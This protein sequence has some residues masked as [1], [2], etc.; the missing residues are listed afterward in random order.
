MT[1]EVYE[2]PDNYILT[3][4][5]SSLW[6]SRLT[7][8]LEARPVSE[9]EKAW[10]PQSIGCMRGL[11]GK[12]RFSP[13]SYWKLLLVSHCSRIARH[14][15]CDGEI[16]KIS[17][18]IA[19]TLAPASQRDIQV[20]KE[21]GNDQRLNKEWER[22]EKRM[23]EE[24]HRMFNGSDSFFFSFTADLTNSLQ[25]QS[26]V[27][28]DKAKPLWQRADE[29]FFWN[30]HMLEGLI[31]MAGKQEDPQSLIDQW[32]I[33][34]IQG[35]VQSDVCSPLNPQHTTTPGSTVN[36][37]PKSSPEVRRRSLPGSESRDL[38]D[39]LIVS[40]RSRHNAGT[41]FKRRGV[42]E[43]G[44]V[45]NYVETEWIVSRPPNVASFLQI[46][47]S[48][49]VFWS[50]PSVWSQPSGKPRLTG[51]E[52]EDRPVFAKHF[53]EELAVFDRI[54]AVN[55]VNKT[56]REAVIGSMYEKQA[57]LYNNENLL[58][59]SFDFH[60]YC[61]GMRYDRIQIL[62]ENLQNVI[63]QMGFCWVNNK[64]KLCKQ[65][66]VFRV[67]CMDCLDRT[68]LVQ[69]A[70]ARASFRTILWKFG[71]LH[72]E[73]PLPHTCQLLYQDMWANNGDVISR[74]YAGTDAL[75]GDF[76][77][78]GERRFTGI[79][80]DGVKSANRYYVNRFRDTYRQRVINT[81]Q[82]I[83]VGNDFVDIEPEVDVE[84]EDD[85]Q[86]L[87]QRRGNL[88]LLIE[89]CKK[90]LLDKSE[91]SASKGW[92][93]VIPSAFRTHKRGEEKDEEVILLLTGSSFY[94][95]RYD[96]SCDDITEYE[97]LPLEE[98]K[99]IV[100]GGEQSKSGRQCVQFDCGDNI[101]KTFTTLQSRNQSKE[102]LLMT[103]QDIADTFTS[104]QE[105]QG[106][107]KVSV[108]RRVIQVKSNAEKQSLLGRVMQ[109]TQNPWKRNKGREKKSTDGPREE[110]RQIEDGSIRESSEERDDE[111]SGSIRESSEERDDEA[112]G[113]GGVSES[114]GLDGSLCVRMLE[115]GIGQRHDQP[116]DERARGS[117]S[118]SD[119]EKSGDEMAEW[120][121][122]T[123]DIDNQFTA[124]DL[125]V[126][127]QLDDLDTTEGLEKEKDSEVGFDSPVVAENDVEVVNEEAR[128]EDDTEVDALDDFREDSPP[129]VEE[130][131]DTD[132]VV[133]VADASQFDVTPEVVKAARRM[134]RTQFFDY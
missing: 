95:V 51:T 101:V 108:N 53:D 29:R 63:S 79:V 10:S 18:I 3:N 16:Y 118:V 26:S 22:I 15:Q 41:R 82:G 127:R 131:D 73:E 74:Q 7:G 32:I 62:A 21:K 31:V 134:S 28:Y 110:S 39:L 125:H 35:F 103:L 85:K 64:G 71:L 12:I 59:V 60:K 77:R 93:L 50:Q 81:M 129:G 100:I 111:A 24:L 119:V 46:R 65:N 72:P 27:G 58:F 68:N 42:D 56:G 48:I 90:R 83:D 13:K 113:S 37:S 99:E 123:K 94:I 30:R 55:L 76:T 128:E 5:E 75:K 105:S 120:R 44:H 34:V 49:P 86:W 4:G 70:L 11:I 91:I 117:E 97:H 84:L 121:S 61:K 80:K 47:G 36:A 130:E 14:P 52:A 54:V 102:E 116:N 40:R 8:H 122:T 38:C 112:S 6:C 45:A 23:D 98:V 69:C 66:S 17:K 33:P 124:T 92:A 19:L 88:L 115:Q 25:R 2:T 1:F 104:L 114:D 106:E 89:Y 87:M 109:W 20:V 107:N 126:K 43:H 132:G 96:E 67:N 57:A 78:T 133:A 9:M